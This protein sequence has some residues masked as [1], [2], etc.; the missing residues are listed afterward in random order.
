MTYIYIYIFFYLYTYTCFFM[1]KYVCACLCFVVH[2]DDHDQ[3][4]L[5]CFQNMLFYTPDLTRRAFRRWKELSPAKSEHAFHSHFCIHSNYSRRPVYLCSVGGSCRRKIVCLKNLFPVGLDSMNFFCCR[6][7]LGF[8]IC[9]MGL[10][11][12][13]CGVLNIATRG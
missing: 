1:L 3:S 6:E 2:Y 13:F 10:F 8:A 12:E 7:S 5:L 11:T 9:Y 4:S